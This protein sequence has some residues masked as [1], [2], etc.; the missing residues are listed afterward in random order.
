MT[1]EEWQERGFNAH[2]AVHLYTTN[3]E[4][5]K[6]NAKN[7]MT[8][9][10]PIAQ[11]RAVNKGNGKSKAAAD[12]MN[13]NNTLYLAVGARVMI[14]S[15]L[16]A[17]IVNRSTGIVQDIVYLDGT[18]APDLPACV[19]TEIDSYSGPNFFP[20]DNIRKKWVPIIPKTHTWCE[21]KGNGLSSSDSVIV[22]HSRTML[23]MRLIWA[24][25]I[26]KSQGQ[27]IN[28]KIVLH[29]GSKEKEH[30]LTYTA[31]SRATRFQ[32]VGCYDGVETSRFTKKIPGHKKMR[33]RLLEEKRYTSLL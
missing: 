30:S 14:S 33:P 3:A 6:H 24:M 27:T 15:N 26:W 18:C 13:M 19:W 5:S 2:K 4:V 29:L 9:G 23:P 10:S 16:H 22:E 21:S 20:D 32:D 17:D 8:L 11:V 12:C 1:H 31:F 7:L 28:N 25:T